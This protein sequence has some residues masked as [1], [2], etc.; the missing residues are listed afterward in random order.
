M[1]HPGDTGRQGIDIESLDVDPQT[2]KEFARQFTQDEL[3]GMHGRKCGSDVV[4]NAI[5]F[6]RGDLFIWDSKQFPMPADN[7]TGGAEDFGCLQVVHTNQ[8]SPGL[9]VAPHDAVPGDRAFEEPMEI[10]EFATGGYLRM[11]RDWL[12]GDLVE[13]RADT[14]YIRTD[15]DEPIE[16][17]GER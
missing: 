7:V 6:R 2:T 17:E 1:K 8:F 5:E 14:T 9:A 12:R 11:F 10:E 15:T 16:N 13:I 4:I 3:E